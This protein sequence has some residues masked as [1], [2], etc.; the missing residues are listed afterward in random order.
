MHRLAMVFGLFAFVTAAVG[1][2]SDKQ[3]LK[4]YPLADCA[5][6]SIEIEYPDLDVCTDVAPPETGPPLT[7]GRF[8]AR[9]YWDL[10]LEEVLRTALTNSKVLTDLGGTVI[11][12]PDAAATLYGP[13]LQETDPRYGV[14]AALSAFDAQFSTSA[15]F[16]K[17]DR[18]LN[19]Q[20]FGGGTRLLVQDAAVF[21]SQLTKRTATGAE[22]TLRKYVEY[23]ANN[24]PG[25]AF[26]S[27][28]NVN[29]E[30]EMRVPLLQGAGA[31]FNRI[32]GPSTTPGL[33]GGVLL[34]RI[35]TDISVADLQIAV[36][37]Y[38]SNVENAYWDLYYAY[39]DLDSKIAARDT[40]LETWR[41]TRALFEAGRRGG[42]A[43]NEAQAREQ[44]FRFEEEVQDALTGRIVDG[45]QT[46]NGSR[47]GTFRGTG[48]VQVA[49]RRLRLLMGIPISDGRLIRPIDEPAVVPIQFD[50]N[51]VVADALSARAE[52][53]QQRWRIKMRQLELKG[54]RNFLLPQLDVVGRY[55]W[56]GFGH[57]L[58]DPKG[59][60]PPFDN[61]FE[62]LMD[63][64]FQE[65][66]LGVE[67][68]VPIGHRRAHA[69]VR[70]AQLN[71]AR[72]QA[73]L[74]EQQRVIL[75]DLSN[76]ISDV[77][78]AEAVVR[79]TYN[80][81]VAAAQQL[82][83]VQA[84]Y[85]AGDVPLDRVLDGQR[86][87]ADAESRHHRAR[88]E[89][90]LA[91][92][93]VH[94]DKGTLLDYY[95]IYMAEG[96]WPGIAYHDAAQRQALQVQPC[97]DYRLHRPLTVASST[98]QTVMPVTS[99]VEPLPPL[100]QATELHSDQSTARSPR[101]QPGLVPLPD[102]NSSVASPVSFQAPPATANYAR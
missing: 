75:H 52:L 5:A 80:R 91:I 27:A 53:R 79:T 8:G 97:I 26:P 51:Q 96:A 71:L 35:N 30:F 3:R 15:F 63:G 83:A 81:R 101:F 85:D 84:A 50:W 29:P 45:T 72:E 90:A 55:R 87:R 40:A 58:I 22:L 6:T 95:R 19:N 41:R 56:R 61:A 42:E 67:L 28:W 78:R 102:V 60:N 23:D 18:A 36:C 86:R 94:Y 62:T 10:H 98:Q 54:N 64:D 48:G 31:E 39:R 69:A 38:V 93:N 57:D 2:R 73:I 4:L 43:E 92:K 65:W 74:K 24:A 37:D 13:A 49:E 89:F 12:A 1:C 11:R 76:G 59:N 68:T 99:A 100:E 88:V 14:E 77:E 33:L 47:A 70:N 32:A 34:A 21:Q 44:Y 16:E 25:N 17:N 20:F 82:A 66:Q 7:I 46:D 9:D